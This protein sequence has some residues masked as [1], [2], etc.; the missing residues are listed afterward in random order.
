LLSILADQ[1]QLDA[2][3]VPVTVSVCHHLS[4]PNVVQKS[5]IA[6]MQMVGSIVCG[7]VIVC[8][9]TII[10]L[11]LLLQWE[12]ALGDAIGNLPHNDSQVRWILWGIHLDRWLV[13]KH[14]ILLILFSMSLPFSL[15]K[16]GIL[17]LVILAPT[18]QTST[19]TSFL[20]SEN[21]K[22]GEELV[23]LTEECME[24][25]N[26]LGT[27]LSIFNQKQLWQWWWPCC[28]CRWGKNGFVGP[29]VLEDYLIGI[30]GDLGKF[31]YST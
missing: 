30:R 25:S 16:L 7:K 3:T 2:R 4:I 29:K 1:C 24:E 5:I 8:C 31:A 19:V 26:A 17:M 23:K 20:D 14:Y 6:S 21:V 22:Q 10:F 18:F 28:C 9:S 13:P 15:A 27:I 12:S 11:F